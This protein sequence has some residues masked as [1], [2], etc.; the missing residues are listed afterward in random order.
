MKT[1]FNSF[2]LKASTAQGLVLNPLYTV[3]MSMTSLTILHIAVNSQTTSLFGTVVTEFLF[4]L[5]ALQNSLT[6]SAPGVVNGE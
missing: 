1:Q 4:A 6:A 3:F 2:E 5:V